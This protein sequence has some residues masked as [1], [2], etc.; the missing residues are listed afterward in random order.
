LNFEVTSII[1]CNVCNEHSWLWKVW[2]EEIMEWVNANLS[3]KNQN[4]KTISNQA[5]ISLTFYVRFFCQYLCAKKIWNQN[6]TEKS[7][8]KHFCTKN[9]WVKCSWNRHQFYFYTFRMSI[10]LQLLFYIDSR[11]WVRKLKSVSKIWAN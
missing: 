10:C 11:W 7:C 1:L 5:S 9:L 4:S 6:V 2:N 8:P 3:I